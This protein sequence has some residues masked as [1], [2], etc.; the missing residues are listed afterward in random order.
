[1]GGYSSFPICIAAKILKIKA[2]EKDRIKK[3]R[4]SV[5]ETSNEKHGVFTM[6]RG[7]G[8]FKLSAKYVDGKLLHYVMETDIFTPNQN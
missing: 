6:N 2:K 7:G 8:E 3:A 4:A 1:M 5:N